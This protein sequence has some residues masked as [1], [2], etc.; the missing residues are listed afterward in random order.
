[1]CVYVRNPHQTID[2]LF[3]SFCQFGVL[4][5]GLGLAQ[6]SLMPSW[7]GWTLLLVERRTS[8]TMSQ[9]SRASNPSIRNPTSREMTSVSVELCDTEFYFFHIQLTSTKVRLP[10]IHKT[11]PE[12][13]FE[14]SRSPAESESWNKPSLQCVSHVTVLTIVIR[15]MNV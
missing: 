1:M 9:R 14:S 13:D 3:D 2:Q 10:K 8:T 5:L 11:P 6:V 7:L 12:V 15:V 4:V